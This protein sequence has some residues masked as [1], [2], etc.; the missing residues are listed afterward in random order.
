MET[1]DITPDMLETAPVRGFKGRSPMAADFRAWY[2][3][4]SRAAIGFSVNV[5]EDAALKDAICLAAGMSKTKRPKLDEYGVQVRS[6]KRD[7]P[8][9]LTEPSTSAHLLSA[10]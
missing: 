5:S 2:A 8:V 4:V 1:F 9:F 7:K 3:D 10:I 6:E